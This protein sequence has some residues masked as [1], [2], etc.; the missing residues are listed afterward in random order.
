MSNCYV[1]QLFVCI[2]CGNHLVE[3]AIYCHTCGRKLR[4]CRV[5][6]TEECTLR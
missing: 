6:I 3:D 5:I 1:A 2:K 4:N